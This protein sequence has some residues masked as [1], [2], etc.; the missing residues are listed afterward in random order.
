MEPHEITVRKIAN[1]IQNLMCN[2]TAVDAMIALETVLITYSV[3]NEISKFDFIDRMSKMFDFT[4]EAY[5]EFL[6]N[7]KKMEE[8]SGGN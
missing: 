6:R 5:Y 1:E 2:H 8:E 4:Y 7:M 3:S